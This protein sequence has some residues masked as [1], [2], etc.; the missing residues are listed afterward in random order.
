MFEVS[1]SGGASLIA[2]SDPTAEFQQCVLG[3]YLDGFLKKV[4]LRGY[5]SHGFRLGLAFQIG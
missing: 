5:L 4:L 3:E 1:H 2:I